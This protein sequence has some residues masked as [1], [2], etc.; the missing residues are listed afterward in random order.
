MNFDGPTAFK[1]IAAGSIAGR[2]KAALSLSF[3]K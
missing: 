3:T 2:R 1:F